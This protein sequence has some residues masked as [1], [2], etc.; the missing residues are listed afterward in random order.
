MEFGVFIAKYWLE[1]AFGLVCAAI[2]WI[3]K[4]YISLLKK[5]RQNHETEIIDTINEKMDAQYQKTEAR[6]NEQYTKTQ[7]QMDQCYNRLQNKINDFIDASKEEDRKITEKIDVLKEGVLSLQ[8]Q[9]FKY[10]CQK[11][12]H[13][14]EPITLLQYEQIIALHATYN[15]LG[16]NHEGDEMFHLVQ[17]KYEN[18]QRKKGGL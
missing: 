1:V 11:L 9:D 7:E 2:A 10:E 12:L 13:K 14:E 4:S 3:A 6:F 5:D 8:G 16:G 18:Q 17:L 15:R